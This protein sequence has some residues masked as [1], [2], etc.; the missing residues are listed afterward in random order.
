[1]HLRV[2]AAAGGAASGHTEKVSFSS[3]FN[4]NVIIVGLKRKREMKW[5]EARPTD[6]REVEERRRDRDVS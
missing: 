3:S 1:M 6:N 2:T 4:V 5:N